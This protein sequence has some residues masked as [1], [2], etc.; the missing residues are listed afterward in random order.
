MEAPRPVVAMQ[1]GEADF[2][3]PE[4]EEDEE[5]DELGD[6]EDAEDE[7][8]AEAEIVYSDNTSFEASDSEDQDACASEQASVHTESDD[9]VVG[10][11][12]CGVSSS[13]G[14]VDE[15][16]GVWYCNE[17]WAAYEVASQDEA[18][19][20]EEQDTPCMHADTSAAGG[21]EEQENASTA[22]ALASASETCESPRVETARHGLAVM[23]VNDGS[24]SS[25]S[26]PTLSASCSSCHITEE[27]GYTDAISGEH[28]CDWC[29]D[30]RMRSSLSCAHDEESLASGSSSLPIEEFRN[31]IIHG[32]RTNTVTSII[33]ETGCGKSSMVP[34]FILE[35]CMANGEKARIM[36]TQVTMCVRGGCDSRINTHTCSAM[37]T[38]T[39]SSCHSP[40]KSTPTQ[41]HSEP[42]PC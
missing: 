19:E 17:C 12:D 1:E 21:A 27:G 41:P 31:D 14:K 15:S 22:I 11:G 3:E 9:D 4:S 26:E 42:L 34:Q 36:V 38:F 30:E 7:Q 23:D 18:S 40:D 5:D 20:A 28:Y 8:V 16:D 32:I 2:G 24:R 29:W 25:T 13:S 37:K 6:D 10:C 33:G 35:D 39:V